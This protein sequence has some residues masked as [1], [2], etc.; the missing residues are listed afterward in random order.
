MPT[1]L[2]HDSL[3]TS[4]SLR[5][6][7]P[8]AQDAFHRF[9]LLA[10]DFGCFEAEPRVLVGRGWPYRNDVTDDRVRGWLVEY[11]VEGMVRLWPAGDR[12]WGH[13]TAWWEFQ[14]HREE[15]SAKNPKGSK[16]KTPVPPK[17]Q[18]DVKA[19]AAGH[20]PGG[21][22]PDVKAAGINGNTEVG[23]N[24]PAFPGGN[25]TFP[26]TQSQYADADALSQLEDS[27]AGKP[28]VGS[29]AVGHTE[30]GITAVGRK[31]RGLG[32]V[33]EA[34]ERAR[35]TP[36][37]GPVRI[38]TE[39][40]LSEGYDA[41][42]LVGSL[43]EAMRADTAGECR[44]LVWAYEAIARKSPRGGPYTWRSEKAPREKAAPVS[45]S[46]PFKPQVPAEEKP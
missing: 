10:D 38:T 2:I 15:Y 17:D 13:F 24:S 32:V 42:H 26:P 46:K 31:N 36:F 27:R 20:F 5:A 41:E 45:R 33:G 44:S 40:L 25:T 34:W 39:D 22:Q 21:K 14:R 6:C 43:T 11:A 9:L 29:A 1:R 12:W 30:V 28:E 37:L 7:T 8:A 18:G 16:R 4:P 19:F 3:L 23:S 35:N